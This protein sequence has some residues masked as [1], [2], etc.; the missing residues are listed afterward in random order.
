MALCLNVAWKLGSAAAEDSTPTNSLVC[1]GCGAQW[2]PEIKHHCPGTPFV[3]AGTKLDL[4]SGDT[5]DSKKYLLRLM[6]QRQPP[7]TF[8]EVPT[9]APALGPKTQILCQQKTD[10]R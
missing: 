8:D 1:G 9:L 3:L 10:G 4:L 5:E 7:V 2:V 6:D